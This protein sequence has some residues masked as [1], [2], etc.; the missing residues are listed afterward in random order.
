MKL[1][2]AC[3]F[4]LALIGAAN[5]QFNDPP[6]LENRNGRLGFEF[7]MLEVPDPSSMVADGDAS[8][9][10]LVRSRVHPHHG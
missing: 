3:G 1:L 9:W 10:G 7:Y 5:A 2:I 8:D 6:A 4:G